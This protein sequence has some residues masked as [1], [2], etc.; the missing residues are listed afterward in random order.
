MTFLPRTE[1]VLLANKS[2][3]RI[4]IPS[5]I[6]DTTLSKLSLLF[7][8]WVQGPRG[9]GVLRND[10]TEGGTS[11]YKAASANLKEIYGSVFILFVHLYQARE[12]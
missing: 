12:V 6:V 8:D 4:R 5:V 1:Y 7:A 9:R 11:C 2:L 10:Y 3:F